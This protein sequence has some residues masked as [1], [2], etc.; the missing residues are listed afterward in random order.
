[1]ARL[2]PIIVTVIRIT[3]LL[4]SKEEVSGGLFSK[5]K[6]ETICELR[7]PITITLKDTLLLI[8]L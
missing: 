8:H 6:I 1:M 7:D 5:N 3:T 4:S 2:L